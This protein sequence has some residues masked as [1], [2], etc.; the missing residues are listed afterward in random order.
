MTTIV[1]GAFD[2]KVIRLGASSPDTGDELPEHLKAYA[3]GHQD[4]HGCAKNPE[5]SSLD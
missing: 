5:K 4:R 3:E 2:R 1:D